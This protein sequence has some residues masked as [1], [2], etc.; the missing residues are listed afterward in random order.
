MNLFILSSIFL[1]LSFFPESLAVKNFNLTT[2]PGWWELQT[3]KVKESFEIEKFEGTYYELALHDW[4]QDPA[5]ASILGGPQ[6]VQSIKYLDNIT[7]DLLVDD[8][9]LQCFGTPYPVPLY[10]NLTD[11]PGYFLGFSPADAFKNRDWPD[12]IVD[13]KFSE[14]GTHYEW[15]IE[16]QCNE[17]ELVPAIRFVGINFYARHYNVTEDYYNEFIKAGY[18]VGLG[19]LDNTWGLYRV[20]M[21]NCAWFEDKQDIYPPQ[22]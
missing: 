2:C 6:C 14:D 3:E 9:T 10:F 13:Y 17:F 19:V 16:F 8:W 22:N 21:D 1:N 12:T 4:T 5:C 20:P 18:D 7:R 15:V 11:I